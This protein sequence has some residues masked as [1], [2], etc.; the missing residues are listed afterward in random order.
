MRKYW[1]DPTFFA[2][3]PAAELKRKAKESLT[4]AK[5]KG[6]KYE[7]ITVKTKRGSICTSWWGKA[8]CENLEKYADYSSRLERGRSYIRTGT[9]V[10]LQISGGHVSAKVQGRRR[11]PYNVDIR[12]GR[13]SEDDCQKIIEKCSSKIDSMEKLVTGEFPEE[14]KDVFSSKGGLFP[15]PR[16]ISFS[17]SCPDWALMCKHVAAVMYGIGVKFDEN[18][19]YFF[20]LR[21]IDVDKFIGVALENRVEKMLDNYECKSNRIIADCDM[22]EIFGM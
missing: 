3:P 15:S 9:V 7:P 12:I 13:L 1:D 10:D 21:G 19:F 5:K 6:R 8:W 4:N 11:T 2:Q 17:C 22:A 20:T 18:P 14:L 16:E